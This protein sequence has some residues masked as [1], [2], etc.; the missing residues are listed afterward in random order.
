MFCR[1]PCIFV[2]SVVVPPD[3]IQCVTVLAVSAWSSFVALVVNNA[4]EGVL[5]RGCV[6]FILH[7]ILGPSDTTVKGSFISVHGSGFRATIGLI[8]VGDT[9]IELDLI[10]IVIIIIA[11][12]DISHIDFLGLLL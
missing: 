8:W 9:G 5:L 2:G 7:R 1:L 3:S 11:G 4:V 6:I 10:S 12:E